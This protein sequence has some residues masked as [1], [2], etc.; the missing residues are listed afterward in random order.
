MRH[1]RLLR[2]TPEAPPGAIFSEARIDQAQ[3]YVSQEHN[4]HFL[5]SRVENNPEWF[6]EVVA[7]Y[8]KPENVRA[9]EL[10]DRFATELEESS[11]EGC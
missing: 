7:V 2:E 3:V 10:L 5:W 11:C 9:L 8:A 6:E 1:F 4:C